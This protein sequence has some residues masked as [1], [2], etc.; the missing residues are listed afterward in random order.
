[1]FLDRN[2]KK[3]YFS[4]YYYINK[5]YVIITKLQAT[6]KSIIGGACAFPFFVQEVLCTIHL[7]NWALF[8]K[9]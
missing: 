3:L 5:N 8:L 4:N 1:M 2:L 7:R 6:N 9:S